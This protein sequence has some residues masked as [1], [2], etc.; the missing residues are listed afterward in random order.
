M[1]LRLQSGILT[2]VGIFGAAW[3]GIS[4]ANESYFVPTLLAA[5]VG[6]VLAAWWRIR[7]EVALVA[8]ALFGYIVGNR[9][10]AQL[11]LFPRLPLLV[12]E[13]VLGLSLFSLMFASAITKRT[14][15]RKDLLNAAV[16]AWVFLGAARLLIDFRVHGFMALRDSAMCYYGLFF[17][18]AQAIG[19]EAGPRRWLH[20]ALIVS[21]IALPLCFAWWVVAPEVLIGSLLVRGIPLILYKADIAATMLAAGVFYFFHFANRG[22]RAAWL[23]VMACFIGAVIPLT[24]AAVLGLFIGLVWHAVARRGRLIG[25]LILIAFIGAAADVSVAFLRQE[26]LKNTRTAQIAQYSASI[27]P[28]VDAGSIEAK[29][30]DVKGNPVDNNFF[31]LI[32]WQT[33]LDETWRERPIFGLGFG[34]DLA[35]QFLVEYGLIGDTEFTARSPHSIAVSAFG[36]MGLLGAIGLG[37]VVIALFRQTWRAV[38]TWRA[39]PDQSEAPALWLMCW[40][41]LVSA[42]FGVVLEGP[43]GAVVFWTLLGLANS[44]AEDSAEPAESLAAADPNLPNHA[45]AAEVVVRP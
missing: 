37:L 40:V 20:R 38:S 15:V 25:A 42:C 21:L 14:P 43:M 36:R 1:S 9:G 5:A 27:L 18:I 34:Y 28:F 23:G 10:F 3:A 8:A 26:P 39:D 33:I 30:G 13:L 32:W 35:S 19:A 17:F 44:R 29:S 11:M 12:A 4:L 22:S 24:R 7:Y 6:V 45:S 16:L 41:I 31:R 2:A